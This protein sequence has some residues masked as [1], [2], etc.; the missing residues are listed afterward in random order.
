MW[1][2]TAMCF[3][4]SLTFD[5]SGAGGSKGAGVNCFAGKRFTDSQ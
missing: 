4:S 5:R 1:S 3:S 2:K